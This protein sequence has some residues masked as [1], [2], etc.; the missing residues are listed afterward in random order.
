MS[1]R[2]YFIL[3]LSVNALSITI[4]T[5]L[6]IIFPLER[7]KRCPQKKEN[8]SNKLHGFKFT[9][10]LKLLGFQ[11]QG[12]SEIIRLNH[13]QL[14]GINENRC[15]P[16]WAALGQGTSKVERCSR[17]RESS[18]VDSHDGKAFGRGEV[19]DR[20]VQQ[21]WT[22]QVKCWKENGGRD[23]R[24]YEGRDNL[25]GL[26]TERFVSRAGVCGYLN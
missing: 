11:Y 24:K 22:E 18:N 6:R 4:G 23:W 21:G 17:K 19:A 1:N 13:L 16:S 10:S 9:L 2:I 14:Q 25:R 5:S 20:R 26:N 3:A 8:H 7:G 12:G 15:I